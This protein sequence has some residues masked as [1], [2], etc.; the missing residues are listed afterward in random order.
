M[1]LWSILI[2]CGTQYLIPLIESLKV[3]C[4]RSYEWFLN[5]L[6]KGEDL[7]CFL[8][9]NVMPKPT[10]TT[11]TC[12]KQYKRIS[13]INFDLPKV[14]KMTQVLIAHSQ[15]KDQLEN[16]YICSNREARNIKFGQQANL[17]ERVPRGTLL[18]ELVTSLPH[19]H[20]ILTNLFTS[21]Y[22]RATLIQFGQQN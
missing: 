1:N 13:R 3:T 6:S 17:I 11:V 18:Q 5:I 4:A 2:N 20:M 8:Q 19:N 7:D 9:I 22:R 15:Q 12:P 21:S 16:L 14:N 10:K